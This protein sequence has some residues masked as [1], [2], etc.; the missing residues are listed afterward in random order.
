MGRSAT[1]GRRA[2]GT[3]VLEPHST[4]LGLYLQASA[5]CKPAGA[6][7]LE[8]AAT[9]GREPDGV[10]TAILE[11][12]RGHLKNPLLL[13]SMRPRLEGVTVQLTRG[14]RAGSAT[15]A[16]A[17]RPRG[18]S[19]RLPLRPQDPRPRSPWGRADAPQT[20]LPGETSRPLPAKTSAPRDGRRKGS[21]VPALLRSYRPPPGNEDGGG[22]L[23]YL[24]GAA[25]RVCHLARGCGTFQVA[26]R[27]AYLGR[28]LYLTLRGHGKGALAVLEE[29]SLI[30]I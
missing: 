10:R 15:Q 3:S 11:Q 25:R 19:P 26:V 18:A 17:L 5:T 13:P 1:P 28:E 22:N 8:V 20:P 29:L 27:T 4:E 2:G 14:G 24:Q 30:H 6:K 7:V 12:A 16:L 21:S 9:V 23:V